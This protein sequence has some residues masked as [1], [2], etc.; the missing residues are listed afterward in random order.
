MHRESGL[1]KWR[2]SREASLSKWSLPGES[3]LSKC[4]LSRETS[5]GGLSGESIDMRDLGL[6]R[7]TLIRSDLFGNGIADVTYGLGQSKSEEINS[8]ID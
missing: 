2:L 3:G 7:D 5:L 1:S 6:D 4:S 8:G